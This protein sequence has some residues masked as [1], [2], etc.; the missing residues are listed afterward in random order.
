MP[1]T[2]EITSRMKTRVDD[3][4]PMI[5]Q[6]FRLGEDIMKAVSIEEIEATYATM[7]ELGIAKPPYPE[8]TV[9]LPTRV[10][11]REDGS[12]DYFDYEFSITRFHYVD[13]GKQLPSVAVELVERDRKL[14]VHDVTKKVFEEVEAGTMEPGFARDS[15]TSFA[16]I[17]T[18]TYKILIVLLATHN[19]ERETRENKLAKFAVGLRRNPARYVTTLRIGKVNEYAYGATGSDTVAA[20][21]TGHTKRPHLRRGH[22][23]KQHYGPKRAFTRE[24]FINPMMIHADE[25]YIAARTA[26]N[27]NMPR[28]GD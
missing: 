17:A 10:I 23:R 7:L 21:K 19:I 1:T 6:L 5:T 11:L 13:K 3:K 8:F 15:I 25:E 14:C 20:G 28:K 4:S 27:I 22:V 16:W 12:T 18:Q 2:I 26:Y 24:V 9:E